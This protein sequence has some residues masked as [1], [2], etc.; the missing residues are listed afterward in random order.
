MTKGDGLLLIMLIL[1]VDF[2]ITGHTILID[3]RQRGSLGQKN[4]SQLNGSL[5][6]S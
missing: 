3:C 5:Y 1:G 2:H 6:L 4:I